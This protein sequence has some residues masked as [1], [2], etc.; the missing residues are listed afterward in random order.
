MRPQ[1][2]WT[3]AAERDLLIDQALELLE[4]VGMRFGA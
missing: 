4:T 3:T 1:V 2:S